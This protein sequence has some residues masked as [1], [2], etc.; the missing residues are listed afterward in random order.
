MAA[1]PGTGAQV[2]EKAG[3]TEWGAKMLLRQL[4]DLRI[5]HPGAVTESGPH[6]NPTAVWMVGDG[7]RAHGLRVKKHKP[8]LNHIAFAV[9]WRCLEDG[10]TKV[11]VIQ[12]SGLQHNTVRRTL[13]ALHKCGAIRVSAWEKD[14]MGR[15]VIP[16]WVAGA[17]KD[18]KKPKRRTE[19]ERWRQTYERRQIQRVT[20]LAQTGV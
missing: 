2:A 12:S 18:A 8:K 4:W 15:S 16:V 6:A 10:A 14:S 20:M 13:D 17:G 19:S 11:E 5:V 7:D 9:L 1:L 3:L